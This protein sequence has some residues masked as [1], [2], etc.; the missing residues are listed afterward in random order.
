MRGRRSG[1]TLIELAM[2]IF[3]VGSLLGAAITPL[4]V[5]LESR[6]RKQTSERLALAVSA[7]Y[8]FALTHRRLPCPDRLP[9]GDGREDRLGDDACEF[10][11]GGLPYIDLGVRSDDAWGR[12]LRYRVSAATAAG[13]AQANFAA[14]DDGICAHGD[15]DFDLCERGTIEVLSRGDDPQTGVIEGK[16][17]YEIADQLPAIVISHGANGYGGV[18]AN[19]RQLPMPPASHLDEWENIDGDNRLVLRTYADAQ[20][21][22]ADDANEATALCQFDDLAMWLSPTI[23]NHYM[24]TSGQL[25]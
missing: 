18:A 6:A 13:T 25:P 22:C 7:L 17:S 3:I 14:V 19:G 1:F 21:P 8:G 5:Q 23:L 12:R 16:F 10:S 24:V 15:S 4:R 2:V 9:R 11:E 20:T